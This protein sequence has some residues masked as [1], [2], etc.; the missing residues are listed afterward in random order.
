MLKNHSATDWAA[1]AGQGGTRGTGGYCFSRSPAFWQEGAGQGAAQRTYIMPKITR[2]LETVPPSTPGTPLA[3][4]PGVWRPRQ[5]PNP[6][7]T[8]RNTGFLPRQPH[9]PR[10][11][12]ASQ[13]ASRTAPIAPS[14]FTP[15]PPQK[16]RLPL[17][18][19]IGVRDVCAA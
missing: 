19:G 17:C 18:L 11:R 1:S 13:A 16:T 10:H 3:R 7:S 14:H 15:E 9:T 8:I 12:Q 6:P 4:Y 2:M 5:V